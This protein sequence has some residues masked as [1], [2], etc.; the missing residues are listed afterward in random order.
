MGIRGIENI[1]NDPQGCLVYVTEHNHQWA[2]QM[3]GLSME[4]I[5]ALYAR[6]VE[7]GVVCTIDIIERPC[8]VD[9]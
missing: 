2:S 1:T 8:G 4:E 7:R 3:T 9:I 6:S 5:G